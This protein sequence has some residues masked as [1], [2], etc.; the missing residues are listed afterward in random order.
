MMTITGRSKDNSSRASVRRASSS[1]FTLME[2][3]FSTAAFAIILL[4]MKMTFSNALSLRNKMHRITEWET[5]VQVAMMIVKRDLEGLT[6]FETYAPE[7]VVGQGQSFGELEFFTTSGTV[8]DFSPWGDVQKVYYHLEPTDSFQFQFTNTNSPG[9]TLVR[10]VRRNITLE[11][12]ESENQ[13]LL[14]EG[15]ESVQYEFWDGV[16]W[17][18][19][20]DSNSSDPVLPE[21]IRTTFIIHTYDSNPNNQKVE[22]RQ[23]VVPIYVTAE[24]P[25]TEE[26]TE[27]TENSGS[28]QN[29][30][31]AL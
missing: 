18:N 7:F 26:A 10:D 22:S 16:T 17:Q 11:I 8:T 6:L 15:V 1:G 3:L 9:Q 31:S 21:A 29:V 13:T 19:S 23:L 14:L 2:I 25:E 30:Q 20:W 24:I 12:G 28:P 5:K 4:V 27:E